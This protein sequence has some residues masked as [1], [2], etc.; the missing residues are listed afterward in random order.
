MSH[1]PEHRHDAGPQDACSDP[2]CVMAVA[3][4]AV[5]VA[6]E[7]AVDAVQ[8]MA[9]PGCRAGLARDLADALLHRWIDIMEIVEAAM[10]ETLSPES[11][12]LRVMVLVAPD[13]GAGAGSVAAGALAAGNLT[14][15][16]HTSRQAGVGA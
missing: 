10:V 2:V 16:S 7:E 5:D 11:A 13:L 14:S 1:H 4:S 8:R 15:R 6:V 3:A 12:S 9:D